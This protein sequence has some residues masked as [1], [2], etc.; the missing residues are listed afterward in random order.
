MRSQL[1]RALRGLHDRGFSGHRDRWWKGPL[2]EGTAYRV[3]GGAR[4]NFLFYYAF[5]H[6]R[7]F[8]TV[9]DF[10]ARSS[11]VQLRVVEPSVEAALPLGPFMPTVRP[12][13]LHSALRESP[14]IDR[15]RELLCADLRGIGYELGAGARPVCVPWDCRVTYIDKFTFEEAKCESFNNQDPGNFVRVSI[16][17]SMEKLDAIE[18]ESADFFIACHVIEH[19]PNVVHGLREVMKKLKPGGKLVLVIP[20]KRFMFDAPRPT[21]TLEHFVAEDIGGEVSHLEHCLEY[22]RRVEHRADWVARGQDSNRS[23]RDIHAHTFTPDSM[24]ELL[25]YLKQDIELFSETEVHEPAYGREMME[26]Y[27]VIT[28]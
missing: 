28:R 3:E 14:D 22:A 8:L 2:A 21:T 27:S 5:G 7:P 20:D 26:F 12:G 15:I 13:D 19:V 6:K 18:P 1:S 17:A 4:H 9:G 11:S 24:R 25:T 16:Y 23:G 10:H